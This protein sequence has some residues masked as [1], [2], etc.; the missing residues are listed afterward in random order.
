MNTN[1]NKMKN[2]IN[3]REVTSLLNKISDKLISLKTSSEVENLIKQLIP[4]A[5]DLGIENFDENREY[6]FVVDFTIPRIYTGK[7][8]KNEFLKAEEDFKDLVSLETV[9]FNIYKKRDK[10]EIYIN[11]WFTYK[12]E[13]GEIEG[14]DL[15]LKSEILEIPLEARKTEIEKLKKDILGL[16]SGT[17]GVLIAEDNIGTASGMYL[18]IDKIQK[19]F[20]EYTVNYIESEKVVPYDWKDAWRNFKRNNSIKDTAYSLGIDKSKIEPNY[21]VYEKCDSEILDIKNK[22]NDVLD[23]NID[24]SKLS[25]DSLKELCKVYALSVVMK[26]CRTNKKESIDKVI[27]ETIPNILNDKYEEDFY[28]KHAKDGLNILKEY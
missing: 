5:I 26:H 14:G 22:L 18:L 21:E 19:K 12:T 24:F 17:M 16:S 8:S 1:N 10:F 13:W 23:D 20:F 15:Q 7:H 28:L 4:D 3:K 9:N 11:V 2:T 25:R 27:K 6:E